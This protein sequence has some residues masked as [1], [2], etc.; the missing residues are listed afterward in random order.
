MATDLQTSRQVFRTRE[1]SDDL[2]LFRFGL[3]QLLAFITLLCLLMAAMAIWSGLTAL[4]LLLATLVVGFH[5]FS[6]ALG[7]RLRWHADQMQIQSLATLA[8]GRAVE[9]RPPEPEHRSPWHEC[10]STPLPWR[11]RWIA[12][13]WFLG[14]V[15]GALL[16]GGTIG[17][18]SSVAGVAVGSFSFGVVAAWFAFVGY[19]FYGVFRHGV[20]DAMVSDTHNHHAIDRR[21]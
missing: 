10:R 4:V 19:S 6:T 5:L 8:A 7:T 13:A 20:Q 11:V 18:R 21:P 17:H 1:M 3:R 15:V 9:P 14:T 12:V 16:L 2:P